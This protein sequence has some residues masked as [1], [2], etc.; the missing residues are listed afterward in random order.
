MIVYSVIIIFLICKLNF[1]SQLK[2]KT[3]CY[4]FVCVEIMIMY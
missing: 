1:I 3:A 4:S 2:K